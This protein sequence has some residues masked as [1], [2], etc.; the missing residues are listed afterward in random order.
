MNITD[1][2]HPS[3]QRT[4]IDI[5]TERRLTHNEQ[6]I[7][8][9]DGNLKSLET[10]VDSGFNNLEAENKNIRNDIA[11][12]HSLIVDKINDAQVADLSAKRT[13][14]PLVV[15]ICSILIILLG[16]GMRQQQ[17]SAVNAAVAELHH[18]YQQSDNA[19]FQDWNMRIVERQMDITEQ[20]DSYYNHQ[21][22]VDLERLVDD[23]MNRINDVEKMTAQVMT[24][25][26]IADERIA[27]L[28]KYSVESIASR[29]DLTAQVQDI[30][31][32]LE[33]VREELGKTSS[34]L[35]QLEPLTADMGLSTIRG[36][37]ERLEAIE[38]LVSD[39][40]NRG[41]RFNND[42]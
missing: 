30:Q 4:M 39:I 20:L 34:Q 3:K 42:Q 23:A 36:V 29:S 11:K 40:D 15:S 21:E 5:D 41:S 28:E 31:N 14:W 7:R 25:N 35:G 1:N 13:S 17:T 9:L 2:I 12:S 32:E 22:G 33:G 38:K 37:S 19:D 26:G 10:R 6:A 27:V 16:W 24:R 8:D 18:K